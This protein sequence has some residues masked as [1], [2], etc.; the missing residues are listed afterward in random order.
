[1]NDA[2]SGCDFALNTTLYFLPS[3]QLTALDDLNEI[4]DHV[5]FMDERCDKAIEFAACYFLRIPCADSLP[6][7]ICMEDCI[8]AETIIQYS[9]A[10]EF[11]FIL[12][13]NNTLS[14][15]LDQFDCHQPESYIN[16]TTE[17]STHCL[18]L[19]KLRKYMYVSA[20]VYYVH[21]CT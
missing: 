15:A 16:G 5:F 9:C 8:V 6:R 14:H 10:T 3:S 13:V 1:M 17:Y 12:A 20:Y 21:S 19:V 4:H 18:P 11:K 7:P 2:A